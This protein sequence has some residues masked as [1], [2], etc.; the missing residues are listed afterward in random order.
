MGHVAGNV[1]QVLLICLGSN[2]VD[3]LVERHTGVDLAELIDLC[4]EDLVVADLLEAHHLALETRPKAL[5]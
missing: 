4:V 2:N 3:H 1:F 5:R